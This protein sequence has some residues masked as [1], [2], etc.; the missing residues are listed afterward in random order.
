[1]RSALDFGAP[2]T[3][4][5]GNVAAKISA[6]VT[7]GASVASNGRDQVHESWVLLKLTQR[8]DVDTAG[9]CDPTE[10]VAGHVDDHDVLGPV[11]L[12]D[13][14]GAAARCP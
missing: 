12:R 6:H 3:D 5:G 2:E 10:V 1:M 9:S 7:P 14:V 13:V 4:A 8:R 11:L